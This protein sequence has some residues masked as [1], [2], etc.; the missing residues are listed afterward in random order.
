MVKTWSCMSESRWASP[1]ATRR[2][3][4]SMVTRGLRTISSGRSMYSVSSTAIVGRGVAAGAAWA[5][6][7]PGAHSTSAS[8]T[9]SRAAVR[10]RRRRGAIGDTAN[11]FADEGGWIAM[12]GP[13]EAERPPRCKCRRDL[14]CSAAM[15]ASRAARALPVV[16]A[17][18]TALAW[19]PL[20]GFV[21]DDTYIHL[22]YARHL[23]GGAGLVFNLGERVY[24]STSP[25]WSMFLALLGRLGCDLETAAIGASL[26]AAVIASA[27]AGRVFLRLLPTPVATCAA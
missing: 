4:S 3:I 23:A 19:L 2:R 13:M 6:P 11:P 22:Q 14:Q 20:A 21:P 25:L 9:R 12:R 5:R 18:V 10:G 24:A 27:V 17:A 1:S 15:S 8:P 16:S 26:L 7:G